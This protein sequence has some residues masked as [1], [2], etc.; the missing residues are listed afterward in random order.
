MSVLPMPLTKQENRSK[1]NK[2][3]R[4]H[5]PGQAGGIIYAIFSCLTLWSITWRDASSFLTSS[6][7]MP[8]WAISTSTW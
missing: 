8:I 2:L 6:T 3:S 7:E 5:P 1:Q 4:K